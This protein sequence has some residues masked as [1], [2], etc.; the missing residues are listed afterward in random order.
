MFSIL[1]EPKQDNA[2]G[3]Y[4]MSYFIISEMR[5]KMFE[6]YSQNDIHLY[7]YIYKY[8]CIYLDVRVTSSKMLITN[9]KEFTTISPFDHF[10]E[11]IQYSKYILLLCIYYVWL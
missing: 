8:K 9:F 10:E 2:Y 6:Q 7:I 5:M 3:K 4:T 11:Q 1:Y